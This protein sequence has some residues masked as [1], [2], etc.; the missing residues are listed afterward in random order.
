VEIYRRA[1]S[2]GNIAM[3]MNHFVLPKDRNLKGTCSWVNLCLG[4]DH[5]GEE[6]KAQAARS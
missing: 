5:H 4:L 6:R 2:R 1:K 3:M